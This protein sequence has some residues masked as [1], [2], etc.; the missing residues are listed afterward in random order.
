M[1]QRNTALSTHMGLA[2][3]CATAACHR[4]DR[5]TQSIPVYGF[6]SADKMLFIQVESSNVVG[7]IRNTAVV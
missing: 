7:F 2:Y 5:V 1:D 4:Q 3:I 6:C